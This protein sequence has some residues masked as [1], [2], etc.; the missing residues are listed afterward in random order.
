[1]VSILFPVV[2]KVNT[3]SL[4]LETLAGQL[5]RCVDRARIFELNVAERC[6]VSATYVK[7]DL[8]HLATWLEKFTYRFLSDLCW[9]ATDPHGAAT[10]WFC[11]LCCSVS[12]LSDAVRC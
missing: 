11:V 3:D 9:E 7:A 2:R 4:A 12:V 8:L 6:V 10:L 1:M 5:H